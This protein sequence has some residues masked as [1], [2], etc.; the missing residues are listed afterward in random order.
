M[1]QN[2][3]VIIPQQAEEKSQV[4]LDKH[5]VALQDLGIGLAADYMLLALLAA[6]TE[7]H[8]F[9]TQSV[10]QPKPF[11]SAVCYRSELRALSVV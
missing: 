4:V 8:T 3:I 9:N 6:Q 11:Y 2:A 1:R 7:T 5:P 10:D